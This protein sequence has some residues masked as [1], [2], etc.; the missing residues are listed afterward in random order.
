MNAVGIYPVKI[1][2]LESFFPNVG[3]QYHGPGY[4]VAVLA[5]YPDLNA[6]EYDGLRETVS[7]WGI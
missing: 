2:E 3:S 5:Q 1:G 4:A 7:S 6:A